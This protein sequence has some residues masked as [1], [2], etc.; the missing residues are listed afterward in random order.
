MI[1][2]ASAKK[3][4]EAYAKVFCLEKGSLGPVFKKAQLYDFFY[5]RG[6]DSHFLEMVELWSTLPFYRNLIECIMKLH[7]GGVLARE[8]R[9]LPLEQR[10]KWG[11]L[12]LTRM[13]ESI[14]SINEGGGVQLYPEEIAELKS[15]LELDGYI[16]SSDSQKLLFSEAA[17]L[18]VKEEQGILVALAEELSF[19]NRDVI[20]HHL[21]LTEE[22]YVAGRWDD[23][24]SN[25]RKF[26]EAILQE[27][28]SKVSGRVE[29]KPLPKQIYDKA[30]LVRKYLNEK[31][32]LDTKEEDAIRSTYGLLSDTGGH[33]YIAQKDQARLMRHLA[34]TYSQFV[35]LRL[36]GF[37]APPAS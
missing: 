20:F 18:D 15:R 5:V 32:L 8:L 24:I 11:Q 37:L 17:V 31:A 35:M 10:E 33:P 21:T 27:V 16:W 26:L 2:R 9:G 25:S 30:V 7:T 22:H 1:G 4:G 14:I 6:Y 36:K 29:G 13:A 3:I 12:C 28:A 23:C 19:D 34:L